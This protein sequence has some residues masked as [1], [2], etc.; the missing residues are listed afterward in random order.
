MARPKKK[1]YTASV[2]IL[3][4]FYQSTGVTAKEAIQSLPI[5]GIAKGMAILSVTHDGKVKEKVMTSPQTFRLFSGG[6]IMREVAL[7]N[8]SLL[9]DGT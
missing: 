1:P 7:K 4:K 2:K 3:G 6:R 5:T 9:F 8:I